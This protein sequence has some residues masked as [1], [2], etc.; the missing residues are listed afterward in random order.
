MDKV[1]F[2]N[3]WTMYSHEIDE[4]DYSLE[5]YHKICKTKYFKE[6]VDVMNG[7][8]EDEWTKK[9]F[10]FMREDITPRYEDINNVDG[11]FWSYRINKTYSFTTWYSLCLQLFGECL[12]KD[13]NIMSNVNGISLSPKNNTT[14]IRIWFKNH[15]NNI[16]KFEYSIPNIDTTKYKIGYFHE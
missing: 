16:Q 4:N 2:N 7:I 11:S 12:F 10:F 9:L 6:F 1:T 15:Q 3:T 13:M 14:T 8:K 5:S